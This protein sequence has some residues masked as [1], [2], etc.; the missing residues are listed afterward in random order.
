MKNSKI[1]FASSNYERY[2]ADATL[3]AKFSRLIDETPLAARVSGKVT[4]IKMHLGRDIGYTTIHPLFVKTLVEKLKSYGAKV[5]ITDQE[6]DGAANR[7]YTREFLGCQVVDACGATEKYFYPKTVSFKT[8]KNVDVAGHIHDADFMVDLSHVKGHGSCG[9]G[10]ACKNIAM[11]CVTTRTRQ[12]IHGLEGGLDWNAEK[13]VHCELCIRG[14]NHSANSFADD[15]YSVNYH[16]CT[17][18]QHCVKVCPTGAITMTAS[19]Q[20]EDFQIG[21][22]L[23]TKTVLDTFEQDPKASVSN[24]Y[25]INFL[26]NITALC[27]CWGLSTPALVPDIGIYASEDIVAIERA[28]VDAIKVENLLPNGIPIGMELGAA[29][30]LLERLHGKNP[31]VQLNELEKAG[32]GTQNYYLEEVR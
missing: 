15:R 29:G 25:Y 7:G 30:H 3:P 27:D 4:A 11:G 24:V 22:A 12:Q 13:C 26:T 21:M 8:F 2:D 28:S 14:C 1:L 9:F 18:C 32:L 16:H 19:N 31:Y 10:G 23:C 17:Y 6:T 20:Y 5:F